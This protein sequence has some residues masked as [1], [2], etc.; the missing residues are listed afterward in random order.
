MFNIFT[1]SIGAIG[2]AIVLAIAI[3]R[4]TVSGNPV[5]VLPEEDRDAPEAKL[6]SMA[7]V[8]LVARGLCLEAQLTV[9]EEI[10]VS[11]KE[12]YWIAESTSPVF[13]GQ[14]VFGLVRAVSVDDCVTLSTLLEFKDYVKSAGS[15]KGI[16]LTNGFFTR[17][18]YQP[19][20][21]P[22]VTLYNSRRVQL[23]SARLGAV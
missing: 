6:Q 10:A 1:L 20:E 5:R 19:L 7:A 16:L 21:G 13:Q 11:E 2:L 9:K 22:R 15:T 12:T 18:V 23:E 4:Q 14:Y 3:T 17:D 8:E